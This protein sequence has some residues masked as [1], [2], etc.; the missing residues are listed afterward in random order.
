LA[1][2][3]IKKIWPFSGRAS[4]IEVRTVAF[5]L[6]LNSFLRAREFNL[7]LF[8]L[9]ASDLRNRAKLEEVLKPST[10]QKTP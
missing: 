1:K 10:Q 4:P 5:E 6:M 3:F 9:N 8:E 2:A 7:E